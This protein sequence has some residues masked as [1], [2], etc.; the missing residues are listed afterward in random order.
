VLELAIDSCTSFYLHIEFH[1]QW[2]H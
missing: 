1:R 2:I